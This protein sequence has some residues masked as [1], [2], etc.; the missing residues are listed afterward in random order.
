[1]N[2][3]Y[4][5]YIHKFP[6]KKVYIGITCCNPKHRWNNG[7]GYQTQKL[8]YRAI[9]KYGWENIEHKILFTNLTKE[10]AEQK[11][12]E[13][14]AK[15]KSN[16]S[17]YGYNIEN[18]GHINCVNESTKR[19]I[20]IANKGRIAPNKGKPMSKEQK[21]KIS[22]SSKGKIIS[23]ETRKKIS[24]ANKGR[25]FGPLSEEIKK[26]ISI[27]KKGTI[28]PNKGKQMKEKQ[29]R[30]MSKPVICVETGTIY[31][32]I[33]NASTQMNLSYGNIWSCCVGRRKKTGGYHWKYAKENVNE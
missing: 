19:K 16:K 28:P 31:Y 18:G 7:K 21:E 15:Y 2:K 1:M 29:K 12:I 20:S 6:N 22:K 9:Q 8:L 32:G 14:I 33:H 5:V 17:K 3:T 30:K 26:K 27:T 25:K 4:K 23:I 24:K 11:E 13:L 10:E